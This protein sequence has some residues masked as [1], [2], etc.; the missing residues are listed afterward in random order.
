[1]AKRLSSEDIKKILEE[2]KSEQYDQIQKDT[3]RKIFIVQ[4]REEIIKYAKLATV[5][6]IAIPFSL[7][8]LITLLGDIF[9]FSPWK[10]F[11]LQETPIEEVVVEEERPPEGF[12]VEVI[13]TNLIKTNKKRTYDVLGKVRNADTNWGVSL[14]KY[15][16]TLKDDEGNKVGE[17]ERESYILPQQEKYLVEI[18]M[19][20]LT[21]A[22][23]VDLEVSLYEVQKL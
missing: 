9:G 5:I 19:E 10:Y 15:K 6:L 4:H 2:K 20:G 7:Y 11:S 22:Y 1:M 21:E 16:F 8:F 18:G 23:E 17:R 14:L 12:E 13:E 3:E